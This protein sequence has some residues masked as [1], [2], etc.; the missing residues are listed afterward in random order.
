MKSTYKKYNNYCVNKY[1]KDIH[2]TRWTPG[3]AN[4]DKCQMECDSKAQCGGIEW[5]NSGWNGSKCHL[6]LTGWGSNKAV[7]GY[8]RGRWQDAEC[9][10]R[11]EMKTCE[12]W[13]RFTNYCVNPA[14]RDIRQTRMNDNLLKKCYRH[15]K[16]CVNGNNYKK[17]SKDP[18]RTIKQCQAECDKNA[19]CKGVEYYVK[20][21]NSNSQYRPGDCNTSGPSTYTKNCNW[22]H[23]NMQLWEKIDCADNN[24]ENM[25]TPKEECQNLCNKNMKCSGIEWYDKK[26]GGSRCHLMLTGWGSNR[27]A[28]GQT[29]GRRYRDAECYVKNDCKESDRIKMV[30]PEQSSNT[31]YNVRE[32]QNALDGNDRTICHTDNN[33]SGW[34]TAKFNGTFAVESVNIKNRPD[35]WGYRLGDATVT[36]DG[37]LCG[38]VTSKTKQGAWYTV[39]CAK[40]ILGASVKVESKGNNPLHFSHIAAFGKAN[41]QC[42]TDKCSANKFLLKTGKCRSCPTDYITDPK[43]K[44]NCVYGKY[45]KEIKCKRGHRVDQLKVTNYAGVAKNSHNGFAGGGW[46]HNDQIVRLPTDEYVRR[47]D[48]YHIKSGYARGQLSK[49]VYFTSKNRIISCYYN[50]VRYS[51]DRKSFNAPKGEYIQHINQY[52]DARKCCGRITKIDTAK[53]AKDLEGALSDDFV[54]TCS[55]TQYLSVDGETRSCKACPATTL[56]GSYKRD[57]EDMTKCKLTC[58]DYKYI[59]DE[60]TACVSDTC[61]TYESLNKDGKCDECKDPGANNTQAAPVMQKFALENPRMSSTWCCVFKGKKLEAKYAIDGD[62]NTMAH[63]R[64][65][66]GHWWSASFKGG[67]KAITKVEI[68]NRKDCCGDRLKNT[69]VYIDGQHCGDLPS[70]TANGVKY[71]VTCVK[72]LTGKSIIIRQNTTYTAL[73]LANVEA[74]GSDNCTHD[75][76]KNTNGPHKCMSSADCTGARYCSRWRWCHGTTQCP[77]V[78]PV[79]PKSKYVHEKLEDNKMCENL[80][81]ELDKELKYTDVKDCAEQA[82]QDGYAHFVFATTKTNGSCKGCK[83]V[84]P[85]A[86]AVN[87]ASPEFSLYRVTPN[88]PVFL[89]DPANNKQ[90][91]EQKCDPLAPWDAGLNK[92]MSRKNIQSVSCLVGKYGLID[93]VEF[94][95]VDGSK[96]SKKSLVPMKNATMKT[97]QDAFVAKNALNTSSSS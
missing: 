69:K 73:Q 59:N 57:D 56:A 23:W 40:P 66:R 62:A 8:S 47:V 91:K 39:K 72:P 32:A 1:N 37:K 35:G 77:V 2:Q 63:T 93:K 80:D 95:S 17:F 22:R 11:E 45:V 51:T 87:V 71:T 68:T 20:T 12:K 58:P 3:A 10:V 15:Q 81:E 70:T 9:Y 94:V 89:Q 97:T 31:S 50:R 64:M 86:V 38:K 19:S 6:M 92:C 48:G 30:T 33:K 16:A 85:P 61:S 42:V 4:L 67:Y 76:R 46:R 83:A 18:K 43:N 41:K 21:S 90:C 44:K 26:A 28:G 78:A 54:K 82:F 34:W 52:Q 65:G 29:R 27:A 14:G 84:V 13:T 60:G 24:A 36:V 75:E 7:K 55:A 53:F 25:P 74:F 5:Y 49:I 79:V 96:H 88:Y